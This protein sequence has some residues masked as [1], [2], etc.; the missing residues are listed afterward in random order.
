MSLR[1]N[2]PV[3]L[4]AE[5]QLVAKRCKAKKLFVFLRMHRHEL[6]D[7]GFQ[8]ELEAA[9]G[10]Q[11]KGGSDAVP[12]ALLA[13]V[14]I[15]QAAF[16]TSDA[17]AVEEALMNQRWQLVLGCLHAQ[18]AP[19]SQGTLQKFRQ[20]LIK[21]DLDR[22]LLERTV[23][24][25][26]RM[27]GFGHR[28]LRAA[29]DASP[30]FGAG[31][32]EDTFNLIGHAARE[33]LRTA[34]RRLNRPMEEVA[35]DAGIPVLNASSVK[36]GLDTDWD[37]PQARAQALSVL[38]GQVD[39]L[40]RWLSAEMEEA[41]KQPPLKDQLATVQRLIEQDTEPD[42]SGGPA[43][44]R[45]REGVAKERQISIRDPQMRHGRKSRSSRVDGYKRHLAVDL[46]S[47]LILGAEVTPANRPEAEG[48]AAM[49]KDIERQKRDLKEIDIDRGYLGAPEIAE[50]IASGVLVRCKPFPIRN[51][52]RYTKLDFEVDLNAGTATCPQRVTVPIAL[53]KTAKFPA[54]RCD[55]CPVRT[56]CTATQPGRG[57]SL[58]IH[59]SEP[60]H[61]ELR[62]RVATREGRLALRSRIPV[63]HRLAHLSQSQGR[64]A[65]YVGQRKNLF[66]VRRHAAVANLH[67]ARGLAA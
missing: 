66:D 34:A 13:M 33:V 57:R 23:E 38:I 30:L 60:L 49:L 26:Q 45:V 1:W 14:T 48:L 5:E 2:L 61:Q 20:R 43:Q 24:L 64:R 36:A 40:S 31:R 42:P 37:S 15:L 27:G 18:V 46:D 47:A 10:Q 25:A 55:P 56:A 9:Y 3:E 22:R 65:R 59:P 28:N 29:F 52:D 58:T 62:Q 12:P 50:R 51:G 35:V 17:D 4:S 8:A 7:E 54:E 39:S 19:F 16:G 21:H 32:V 53:G 67:V 6:F 11:V 44:R 41:T 63:E